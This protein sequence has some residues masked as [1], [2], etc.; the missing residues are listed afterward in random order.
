MVVTK[1]SWSCG[2]DGYWIDPNG[3]K[4]SY[5]CGNDDKSGSSGGDKDSSNWG[6]KDGKADGA[7]KDDAKTLC[8]ATDMSGAAAFANYP[9][10]C[11]NSAPNNS[12][13]RARCTPE[14]RNH[15][16]RRPTRRGRPA[17]PRVG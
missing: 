8:S 5:P 6:D 3:A 2:A 11:I 15:W 10:T 14:A 12:P 4:S 16:A 1:D 13:R 17:Q 7:A 9:R